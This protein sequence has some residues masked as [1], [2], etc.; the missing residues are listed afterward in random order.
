[1]FLFGFRD[2]MKM[3][4]IRAN[5]TRDLCACEKKTTSTI[6]IHTNMYKIVYVYLFFCH[7]PCGDGNG[8]DLIIGYCKII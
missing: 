7:M 8:N 5:F 1:M 6:D 2:A 3:K 4:C